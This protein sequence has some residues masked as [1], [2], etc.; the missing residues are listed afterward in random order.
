[1]LNECNT[2]ITT[3]HLQ[4]CRYRYTTS[5]HVCPTVVVSR[6]MGMQSMQAVDAGPVLPQPEYLIGATPLCTQ[7]SGLSAGQ[8]KLCQ[9]YQDHM[10][11]VSK[12]AKAGINECQWQ[13]RHRRWNCSTVHDAT[14]FGPVLKI[15]ELKEL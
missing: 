9:L 12:G 14:V 2:I 6:N 1:M 5:P 8:T 10:P 15:C 4:V 3:T 13:F 7:I 11:G